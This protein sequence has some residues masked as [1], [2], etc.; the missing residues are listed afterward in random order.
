MVG[1]HDSLDYPTLTKRSFAVG[2]S[3][4]LI[5]VLGEVLITAAGIQVPA[6]ERTLLFDAEVLGIII[7]LLGPL[8]FGVVLPLTE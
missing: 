5:G 2:A 4:F 1:R 8:V 6:W 7:G 3:L